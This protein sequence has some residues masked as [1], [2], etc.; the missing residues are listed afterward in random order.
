MF[1]V[2]WLNSASDELA[3]AWAQ[4][5]SRTRRAITTAAHELDKRLAAKPKEEGESRSKDRRVTFIPPLA[6]TFRL[7]ADGQTVTVLHIRLFEKRR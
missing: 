7:E 3:T 6:V 4:S 1:R 2:E 5:S